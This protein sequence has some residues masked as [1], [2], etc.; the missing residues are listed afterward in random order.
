MTRRPSLYLQM[1]RKDTLEEELTLRPT[2]KSESS[3]P[4][5]VKLSA[6]VPP[7]VI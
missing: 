7:Y 4:G 6:G 1:D 3:S 2:F 5:V